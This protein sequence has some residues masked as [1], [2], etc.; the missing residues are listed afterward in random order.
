VK[1]AGEFV[2]SAGPRMNETANK[3]FALCVAGS[4]IP[5]LLATQHWAYDHNN[6]WVSPILTASYVWLAVAVTSFSSL[7]K[8]RKWLLMVLFLLA[9]APLLFVAYS[10]TVLR[11]TGFA[12]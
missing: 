1:E 10:L 4:P 11:H 9:E 12:P 6:P 5:L 3:L 2:A 8:R 7:D